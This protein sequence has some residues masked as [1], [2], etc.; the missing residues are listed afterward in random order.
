MRILFTTFAWPSH[1]AAMVPLAWAC[2]NA[3]HDVRMASQP[4]LADVILRS[5]LPGVLVGRDVDVVAHH[6]SVMDTRP[7][8]G[9]PPPPE[10]WDAARRQRVRRAL[11][12]FV[13]LAE[14]MAD[15]LI[16]FAR[17]WRPDLVVFDPLSYAGPLAA[18]LVGVPAV[19]NLFGP[20]ITLDL[21]QEAL[22]PLLDRYGVADLDI[23]G[24]LTV[25]PC[26]PGL[27]LPSRHGSRQRM[28][29]VPHSGLSTVPAWLA[30]PP[31]RRRV[32]LTWGTSTTRLSTHYTS[33]LPEILSGLSKVDAEVVLAVTAAD[34]SLLGD[35]PGGVRIAEQVP[36]E[37]LLPSCAAVVHQGGAGTTLTSLLYGLPQL[38]IAQLA[39]QLVNAYCVSRSGAGRYLI[40]DDGV[41]QPA[42]DGV[43][44]LLDEPAYRQAAEGLRHEMRAAPPPAGIVAVL[45]RIARDGGTSGPRP[46]PEPAS[47][48]LAQA[49]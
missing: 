40:P 16:A 24:A 6:R 1:Y 46:E 22:A 14:A 36:L 33:W 18:R 29:Y 19:R 21:E 23:F 37:A 42:L 27:Q 35:L 3:G 15:D 9:L 41:G 47:T 31:A 39:D 13:E 49:G 11:A 2:R 30:E 20:D 43:T 38:V 10:Q 25:D 4:E 28:R 8:T 26:P 48:A 12:I 5:G 45:E 44:S 7:A 32:C 17:A 34:R